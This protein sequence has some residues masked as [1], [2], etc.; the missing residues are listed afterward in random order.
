MV[1]TKVGSA[2]KRFQKSFNCKRLGNE[3][4]H[5]N[6]NATASYASFSCYV[7]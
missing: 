7:L 4:S 1:Q 5:A 2:R 6:P 3:S